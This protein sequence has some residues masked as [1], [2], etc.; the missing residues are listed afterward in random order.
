MRPAILIGMSHTEVIQAA[1]K[2]LDLPLT[3]VPALA[4]AG[5]SPIVRT[6]G[7]VVL[8]SVIMDRM[9]RA[10]SPSSVIFSTVGG[11]AYNVLT[12]MVQ[13]KPFDFISPDV[14]R[15]LN[16]E[17]DIVPYGTIKAKLEDAMS[18]KDLAVF[19]AAAEAFPIWGHIES[20]PP[21][22]DSDFIKAHIDTYFRQKFPDAKVA[23]PWLRLKMWKLH[24]RLF[25]EHCAKRKIRF[26]RRPDAAVDKDGF[27]LQELVSPISATHTNIAYGRLVATQ[28]REFIG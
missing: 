28:L 13:G 1:F 12:M 10:L 18:P 19:E 8:N 20:P 16:L 24:S 5:E 2:E 11:N 7:G 21:T 4:P 6:E 23:D 25:Q 17:A 22:K 3:W 14:S 26:I 27:L 15:P 9:K